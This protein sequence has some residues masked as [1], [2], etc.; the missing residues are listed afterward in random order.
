[1]KTFM[2]KTVQVALAVALSMPMLASATSKRPDVLIMVKN[3][4]NHPVTFRTKTYCADIPGTFTIAA[5]SSGGVWGEPMDHGNC[6][7]DD[8]IINLSADN[9]DLQFRTMAS[10]SLTPTY[11]T[12]W[13]Y[14]INSPYGIGLGDIHFEGND[15]ILTFIVSE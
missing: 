4:T 5:N 6:T 3:N 12:K 15:L 14:K 1:M 2:Q 9:Y 8:K 13:D 7:Y 10:P 11:N